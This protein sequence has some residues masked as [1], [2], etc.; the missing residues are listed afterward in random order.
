[1]KI[2]T[3]K[4][5]TRHPLTKDNKMTTL[6]R[7]F[8]RAVVIR[9]HAY[10]MVYPFI[11][12][13]KLLVKKG[14]STAELQI[15]TGMYEFNEMFLVAHFLTSED[16]FVD[17]GANVGVYTVLASGLKQSR[18]IAIEPDTDT[19]SNLLN[20]VQLNHIGHNVQLLNLGVG[21]EKGT[22]KFT[23]GL[24]AINHIQRTED[25]FAE[26]T[27]IQIER[28]DTILKDEQPV[29]IKVD[30]E[31][32]ETQVIKGASETLKKESLKVVIIELNGLANKYSFDEYSIH[33]N[34]LDH[35]FRPYTYNPWTRDFILM[36]EYGNQ[37]TV[38][39]RDVDFIATRVKKSPQYQVLGQEI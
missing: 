39:L 35:G 3:L 7:F 14:M 22:V 15:Y 36:E 20:N 8:K 10:P 33:K 28:L 24:D 38:Y 26:V 29:V 9:L 4:T 27:E 12:D 16:L 19:F 31:G 11:G 34:L 30:V 13:T 1:M 2:S 17:V 21:E 6:I 5:I 25:T 37:N 23:K 32:Y 18:T